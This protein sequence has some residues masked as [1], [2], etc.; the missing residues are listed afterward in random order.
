[1]ELRFDHVIPRPLEEVEAALLAADFAS[2]FAARGGVLARGEVLALEARGRELVRTAHFVVGGA[3][4]VGM[5]GRYGSVAWRETVTWDR[6]RHAGVFTVVPEL[7]AVLLRRVRCEGSYALVP[8]R[9]NATRRVLVARIEVAVPLVGRE[10]E[11]R[12]AALLRELFNDEAAYLGE[13]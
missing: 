3:V 8:E 7:P 13:G 6:D 12:V 2:R 11:A 1:V 9:D 4:S 10:V 5:L